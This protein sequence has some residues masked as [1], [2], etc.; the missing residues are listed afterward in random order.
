M[1]LTVVSTLC[2]RQASAAYDD[3][4][5][6]PDAGRRSTPRDRRSAIPAQQ[7]GRALRSV[8]TPRRQRNQGDNDQCVEDHGR[9]N[10]ALR[11]VQPMIFKAASAG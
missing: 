1:R 3:P 7:A 6:D 11:V 4:V 9:E 10:C 8:A 5:D 2:L